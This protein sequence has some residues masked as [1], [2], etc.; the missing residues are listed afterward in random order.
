MDEQSKTHEVSYL[1]L[2]F[3]KEEKKIVRYSLGK[4]NVIK[5]FIENSDTIT[6]NPK[7]E[8]IFRDIAREIKPNL[9]HVQYFGHYNVLPILNVASNLEIQKVLSTHDYSIFC[10]SGT[11][12][13]NNSVCDMKNIMNCNC[14]EILKYSSSKG[15]NIDEVKT[16]L[17]NN[18]SNIINQT[19]IIH[20][21][22]TSQ[23]NMLI[24]LGVDNNKIY[25]IHYGLGF[26]IKD[27]DEKITIKKDLQILSLGYLGLITKEKGLEDIL[28][29]IEKFDSTELKLIICVL[30]NESTSSA[31]EKEML[32]RIKNNDKI[33]LHIN[34]RREKLYEVLFQKINFLIVPSKWQET[35]PLT[36][37]ESFFFK[38]PV[39]IRN[40]DSIV[41]KV[42][43]K[44]SFIY[45][46]KT[47][48]Y[49]IVNSLIDGRD[50]LN[51]EFNV[52]TIDKYSEE[53][54]SLYEKISK[55][56]KNLFLNTGYLC[57]SSC[58]YCVTGH[59][60]R[61]N[62]SFNE[63]S[64][65]LIENQNEFNG[66]ILTGGEPTIDKNF[67]K[68]I[69]LAYF[70]GYKLSIQTNGR[71]FKYQDFVEKLKK[72]K[73]TI[74]I[75][76]NGPTEKIHDSIS[77][78]K[79]SFSQTIE[80]INAINKNLNA[81]LVCKIIITKKNKDYLTETAK[82]AYSLGFSYM[83]VVFPT[84][85]GNSE[86]FFDEIIPKYTD[87]LNELFSC[88]DYINNETTMKLEIENIPFCI[89]RHEDR[90]FSA[91]ILHRTFL[92]KGLALQAS[93]N[94]YD[95]RNTRISDKEKFSSCNYCTYN[96]FCEGIYS[97]YVNKN[98]EKE[99]KPIY[100]EIHYSL[101]NR[102]DL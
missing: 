49:K 76:L 12:F 23:K 61:K 37:Y 53:I 63:I 70:L 34:V 35:G 20:T 74:S 96:E 32:R 90:P 46:T 42:S 54:F 50:I 30:Y 88:I 25:D 29:V 1:E 97:V 84:P 22:S 83:T 79:G 65:Y 91:D 36:L 59:S 92:L 72:Y 58:E 33:E 78:S 68:T 57:N 21:P 93:E 94:L 24:S 31:Y 27:L 15:I 98:S 87:I 102:K 62:L 67:L 100:E 41:E 60:P 43:E 82:L 48:F 69:N 39:I 89:L 81:Y 17:L 5:A 28:D 56:G 13:K 75:P 66:L 26:E 80:G 55:M 85:S 10:F 2:S 18:F 40:I 19:D 47:D 9:V 45:E 95:C 11:Y 8:S 77:K 38:T 71:M 73:M 3:E 51:K 4:I 6:Y 86:I 64:K 14:N 52:K 99:F 16:Q 7:I 101:K 44:N